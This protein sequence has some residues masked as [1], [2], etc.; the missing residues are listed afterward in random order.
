[1]FKAKVK[2]KA[3]DLHLCNK[4][5]KQTSTRDHNTFCVSI[6]IKKEKNALLTACE[7]YFQHYFLITL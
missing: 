3:K 5:L 4:Q 2:A 6:V 7:R 1:M